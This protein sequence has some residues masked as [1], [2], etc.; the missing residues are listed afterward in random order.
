MAALLVRAVAL[1]SIV[2]FDVDLDRLTGVNVGQLRFLVV[3]DDM[4][5]RHRHDAH[6]LR[7]GL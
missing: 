7:T 6:E 3:G 1:V 5:L 4:G 2:G